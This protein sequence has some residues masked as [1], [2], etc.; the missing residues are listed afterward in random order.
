VTDQALATESDNGRER[1][2]QAGL[3]LFGQKG[4][5]G[6]SVTDLC[7][8]A[9]VSRGLIR[10][11]FGSK[12]A[13]ADAVE[14]LAMAEM[15]KIAE[16]NAEEYRHIGFEAALRKQGFT[17]G[18]PHVAAYI[19]RTMLDPTPRNLKFFA[20]MF[21]HQRRMADFSSAHTDIDVRY[22]TVIKVFLDFGP[23]LLGPQIAAV[24]GESINNE[25]LKTHLIDVYLRF[26]GGMWDSEKLTTA[27]ANK[28]L[29]KAPPRDLS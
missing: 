15:D 26:A 3:E 19:R 18:P 16:R 7:D 20:R 11:H 24:F 10:F 22:L 17:Y 8:H 4:F 6:T 21:E 9:G 2:L 27:F 25:P 29:P 1:L 28:P 23:L 5:A 12:Q 13:L 14:D